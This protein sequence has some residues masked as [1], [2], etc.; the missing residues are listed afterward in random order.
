MPLIWF[1]CLLV[2][3]EN[4]RDAVCPGER[5]QLVKLCR[6]HEHPGIT[7]ELRALIGLISTEPKI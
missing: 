2:F 5:E 6:R 3:L 1:R 7:P 4:Y